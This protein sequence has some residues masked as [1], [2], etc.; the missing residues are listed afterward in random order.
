MQ[1]TP[2]HNNK[3]ADSQNLMVPRVQN[4]ITKEQGNASRNIGLIDR[5]L[6]KASIASVNPN[7]I[8]GSEREKELMQEIQL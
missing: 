5:L 2:K 7:P 1:N 8:L 3:L 6:N 4:A